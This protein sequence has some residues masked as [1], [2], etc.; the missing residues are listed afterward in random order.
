MIPLFTMNEFSDFQ[1]VYI[2]QIDLKGA[3]TGHL[4]GDPP[5]LDELGINLETIKQ[6][7][8]IIFQIFSRKP[9]AFNCKTADAIGPLIF[10]VFYSLFLLFNGKIHFG[11]IYFLSIMSNF[12]MY[13]F[14]NLVGHHSIALVESWSV[15]GYSQ[16]PITIFALLNIF[17]CYFPRY[18]QVLFGSL[19]AGW[20]SFTGAKIFT[21]FL[22]L[23]SLLFVVAYPLFLIYFC[24]ALIV[25]F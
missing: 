14:L 13:A 11:Y 10:S 1:D 2:D 9:L 12:L 7:S 20:A 4:S 16:L 21:S 23:E 3:F 17:L 25:I 5:L 19:F 22:E 8:L 6:E 24:F 15:M 18:L